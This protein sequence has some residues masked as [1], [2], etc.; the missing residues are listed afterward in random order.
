MAGWNLLKIPPQKEFKEYVQRERESCA[1]E[2][3]YADRSIK[4]EKLV[5]WG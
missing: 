4:D 2:A 5:H 1:S 3:I